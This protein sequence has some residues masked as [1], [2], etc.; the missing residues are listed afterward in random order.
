VFVLQT[1]THVAIMVALEKSK[2]HSINVIWRLKTQQ[3]KIDWP[4]DAATAKIEFTA[5]QQNTLSSASHA[6]TERFK[7]ATHQAI[8]ECWH[9]Q[10]STGY[11]GCDGAYGIASDA[12]VARYYNGLPDAPSKCEQLVRC[13]LN[14]PLSPP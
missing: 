13:V 6:T 5:A 9:L 10:K 3:L 7:S 4:V 14:D 8:C 2:S 12:C 1:P 11:R